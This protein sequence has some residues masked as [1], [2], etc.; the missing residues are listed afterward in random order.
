MSIALRDL[1]QPV[2]SRVLAK[3]RTTAPRGAKMNHTEAR[4][5]VLLDQ[6]LRAGAVRWFEYEPVTFRLGDDTRYTPDF[7]LQ[8][9][10]GTIE[11]H[12]VK[13]FWRD[14][15]RVKIKVAARLFP[16]F[17][18]RVVKA[19]KGGGWTITEA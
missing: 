16:F 19:L 11:L 15:A 1:P 14:D 17:T 4:Y 5:A 8:L 3:S 10:D 9:A 13:G 12:E 18:F 7:M 6:R 2:Q